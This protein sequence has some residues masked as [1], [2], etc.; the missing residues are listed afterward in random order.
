M[1]QER[2]RAA[3]GTIEIMGGVRRTGFPEGWRQGGVC[4][5]ASTGGFLGRLGLGTGPF[6]PGFS[7]SEGSEGSQPT[8]GRPYGPLGAVFFGFLARCRGKDIPAQPASTRL[9]P[10]L[11]ALPGRLPGRSPCLA[12]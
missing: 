6:R 4:P 12:S 1:G 5:A 2:E 8:P 10:V 3:G 9:R 11:L 7:D